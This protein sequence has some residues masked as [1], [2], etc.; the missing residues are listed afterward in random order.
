MKTIEDYISVIL[1][2]FL[3][4]ISAIAISATIIVLSLKIE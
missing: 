3:C 2:M 4:S 1:I